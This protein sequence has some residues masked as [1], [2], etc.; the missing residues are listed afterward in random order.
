MKVFDDG[1]YAIYVYKEVGNQ[2]HLPHCHVR[3]PDN[4]AVL[5]IP[6]LHQI[7]G[8][9]LPKSARQMLLTRLNDICNSWNL[10]NPERSINSYE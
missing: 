7:A 6:L 8:S 1:K 9:P 10:L 2:H 5:S 4:D 3:W